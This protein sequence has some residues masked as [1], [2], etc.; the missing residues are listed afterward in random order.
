MTDRGTASESGFTL[1]EAMVAMVILAISAVGIIRAAEAHVDRL[2]A[3]ETRAAAQWVAENAL[4]EARLGIAA[5]QD[6]SVTMLQGHWTVS[7]DFSRSDDPD[8]ELATVS[9][10]PQGVETPVI[11]LRGFVDR[12]TITP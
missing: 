7:T 3:L 12:G 10:M 8:L 5:A 2:H 9:V 4:A 1:I 11:T 6:R